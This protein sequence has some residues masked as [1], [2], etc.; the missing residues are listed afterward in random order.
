MDQSSARVRQYIR[1]VAY[2]ANKYHVA[3]TASMA[4]APRELVQRIKDADTESFATAEEV[5][6]TVGGPRNEAEDSH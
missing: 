1:S 4:G 2:P 5:L 6:V 3:S